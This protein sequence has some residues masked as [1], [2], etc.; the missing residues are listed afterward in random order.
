MQCD[1]KGFGYT[2]K[3][4]G[5]VNLD[6]S[7]ALNN[8]A[9]NAEAQNPFKLANILECQLAPALFNTLLQAQKWQYAQIKV[10]ANFYCISDNDYLSTVIFQIRN[11]TKG[12]F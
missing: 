12:V 2:Q 9:A 7:L 6:I 8:Y 1:V 3:S 11:I 4:M 10:S 5:A